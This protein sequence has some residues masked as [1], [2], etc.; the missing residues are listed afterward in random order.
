[1][2]LPFSMTCRLYNHDTQ[3]APH[4]DST[5]HQTQQSLHPDIENPN[6]KNHQLP[7]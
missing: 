5:V 1:M 7:T 3:Q 4:L 2:L 6:I